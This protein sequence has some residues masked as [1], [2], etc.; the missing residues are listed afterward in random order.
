M[1]ASQWSSAYWDGARHGHLVL[2]RCAAC[3]EVR[4]YPRPLCP[5]CHS[6]E[7]EVLTASGRGT[8][9]SWTVTNH[10]FDPAVVDD[11]PYV[12]VTVDLPEGG[13][14]LGRFVSDVTLQLD[15]AVRVGFRRGSDGGPLLEVTAHSPAGES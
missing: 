11:V 7:T 1:P 9:H 2:Q 14:V 4:H 6:F 15:M 13:R 10:A 12:L 3:G 8:V 5:G